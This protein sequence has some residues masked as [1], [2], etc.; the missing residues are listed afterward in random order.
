M[1]ILQLKRSEQMKSTNTDTLPSQMQ[2]GGLMTLIL[3]AACGLIV[4]NLY[5]AQPVIGLIA[6]DIHLE[7]AAAGLI[8]T[9]TQIGYG[10][11][12]L[13]LVPLADLFENRMLIILF[14]GMTILALV[15]AATPLF[16]PFF[17]PVM[18]FVG[19]GAVATQ[20]IVPF[21]SHL[22][23]ESVRGRTVGKVMSGLMLGIVLAR[24]AAS[25]ISVY[26][27]WRAI[28]LISAMLLAFVCVVMRMILPKRTVQT[29][30]SYAELLGSMGKL[31]VTYPV[32]RR[33]ALYHAAFFAA[34]S[35]FWTA[36]PL[37]LSSASFQMTQTGIAAFGM[38]G[39][40]GV[41]AAPIAGW[42]A[43]KGWVRFATGAAMLGSI[44]SFLVTFLG[45]PGSWPAVALLVIAAFLLD[46]CVTTNLVLGQRELFQLPAEYRSRLNGLYMTTFFLGGAIGSVLGSWAFDKGGWSLVASLGV[47]APAIAFL[48]FLTET[49]T[50]KG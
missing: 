45:H 22:V 39:A 36:A 15:A 21:A 13:L 19:L 26:F 20:I 11:G 44:T 5:Y 37:Y 43:D 24:P 23:H 17:L 7:P 50:P 29:K 8:V 14:L 49:R 25:L 35:L 9:L 41:L 10:L 2:L 27:S 42:I 4:A 34:F 3:S 18:F 12:L 30:M 40:A 33:R 46:Y 28:F 31:I 6:S 38:A 32:L 1:N 47:A 48:Y 16:S